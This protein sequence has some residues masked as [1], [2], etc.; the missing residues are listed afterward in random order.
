M[1]SLEDGANVDQTPL[2]ASQTSVSAVDQQQEEERPSAWY[3]LMSS[4][5]L[6]A[7]AWR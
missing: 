4:Y 1:S 3:F 7:W 6:A 2:L 5:A